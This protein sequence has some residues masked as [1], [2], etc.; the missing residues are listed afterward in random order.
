MRKRRLKCRNCGC[1]FEKEV[2]EPGEAEEKRCPTHPVT[3]PKCGSNNV[4]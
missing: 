4:E 2:F 1:E 3:C